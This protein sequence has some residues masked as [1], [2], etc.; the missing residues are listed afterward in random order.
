MDK[1]SDVHHKNGMTLE[2]Q[3][4][5]ILRVLMTNATVSKNEKPVTENCF[6]DKYYL[7]MENRRIGL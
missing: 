4:T 7:Y 5:V 3:T 2:C 1:I 6:K